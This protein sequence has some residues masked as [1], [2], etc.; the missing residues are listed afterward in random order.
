MSSCKAAAVSPPSPVHSRVSDHQVIDVPQSS[1][2]IVP[3]KL[4]I[5]LRKAQP[6][7]WG[8]L[9]DPNRR[10]EPEP[11]PRDPL[12]DTAESYWDIAD[13]DIS[14][15]DEDWANDTPQETKSRETRN[16]QMKDVEEEMKRAA[17][18][19][20][21]LEEGKRQEAVEGYEDMPDLE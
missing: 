18:E 9:E 2:N 14:D 15:S 5:V 1:V 20:R 10:A 11:E 13:D 16:L 3:S 4:E 19:R 8:K 7:S 17:E 12:E 21:R 6:L